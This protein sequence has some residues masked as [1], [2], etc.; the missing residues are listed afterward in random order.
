M[1]DFEAL[2]FIFGLGLAAVGIAML[3]GKP[4]DKILDSMYPNDRPPSTS[5]W[6]NR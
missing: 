4:L 2:Q 1:S 5:Y 3:A 6:K